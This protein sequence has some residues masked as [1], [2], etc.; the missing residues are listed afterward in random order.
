M[1]NI[2]NDMY[3][4]AFGLFV[5]EKREALDLTQNELAEM[6][7]IS[8]PYLSYIENG[9]READ[10]FLSSKICSKLNTN[11]KE[12]ED[13]IKY[14]VELDNIKLLKYIME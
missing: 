9:D 5:K 7:G 11:I 8:Q 1:S 6:V 2:K 14:Y 13:N 4:K 10:L 12:F 3:K